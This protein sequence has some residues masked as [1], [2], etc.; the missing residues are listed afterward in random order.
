MIREFEFFHGAALINLIH[1]NKIYSIVTYPSAYNASYV[2]NNG[3][4]IYIKYSK[5][6][7]S[8]WRF[9]FLIEHQDE[10][11]E[12]QKK[13][14]KLYILLVCNDDGI[15]CLDFA[16]LKLILDHF[17]KDAEWVAVY[18]N[19]REKYFIRG[20]DGELK[21]KMGVNNFSKLMTYAEFNNKIANKDL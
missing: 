18:R 1:N 14:E 7:I 2:I 17:H 19:K 9:T 8:P 10:I 16:Q 11:Q 21:V 13:Y 20:S 6:R 15:V 5:K 4:G 3:I 12:M